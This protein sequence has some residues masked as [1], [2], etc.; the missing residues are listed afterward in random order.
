MPRVWVH[1]GTILL[2]AITSGSCAPGES[3]T[4]SAETGRSQ[5]RGQEEPY[6]QVLGSGGPMHAEGRG[7]SSYALWLANR[8]VIVV[9]MGAD[10]PA[11]LAHAGAMPGGVE[12]L[13]VSHLHAD[14]VSGLPD[15]LWGEMAAE[16][17]QPLAVVGPDSQSEEFPAFPDFLERLLGP[18][19]AFPTLKGLQTGDPFALNIT[20]LST[21]DS[22]P[23]HVLDRDNISVTALS[24]PHGTAPAL[25]YRVEGPNVSIVFAG[26]Q[27]GTH[28]GFA[29]FAAGVDVLI[30]HAT[31]N[32]AVENHP[33]AERVGIP[34]R[35]GALARASGAKRVVLSHLMGQPGDSEQA[36][37]WSLA[38]LDG[39]L[40]SIRRQF[41][42][43]VIVASDLACLEL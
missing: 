26:D 22:A 21:S 28:P 12:V 17:H 2:A 19:G 20:T 23:Q 16:R 15:F 10:T 18:D 6:L 11:K 13:L 30:F 34:S 33:V 37:L 36:G 38:D 25:A 9:D 7:G 32:D 43:P 4:V 8:P 31:V 35:L 24:V 1:I 27:S 39:V 41:Q 29:E 14:H 3:R 42:G 40:R 5:C